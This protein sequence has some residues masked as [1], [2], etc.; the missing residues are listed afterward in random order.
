MEFR[1]L[2]GIGFQVGAGLAGFSTAL[3]FHF[4]PD[5]KSSCISMTY[6]HQGFGDIYY[7]SLFGP[8]YIQ[9]WKNGFSAQLGMGFLAEFGPLA[10]KVFEKEVPT[11]QPFMALGY[12]F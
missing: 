10:K 2:D 12:Y 7:A 5:I 6:I 9:R 4:D 8:S 1:L 11:I 3:N